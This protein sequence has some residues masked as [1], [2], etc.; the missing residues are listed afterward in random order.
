MQGLYLTAS[1]WK[2]FWAGHRLHGRD[3]AG[4][5]LS[6][7]PPDEFQIG[8]SH[9]LNDWSFQSRLAFRDD[10]D[11]IAGEG[12]EQAIPAA[13]LLS[14]SAGYQLSPRWKL[15]LSANNLLDEEYYPSADNKAPLAQGRSFALR[16]SWS[17]TP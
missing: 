7:I 10:K 14:A 3:A 15:A 8:L 9:E 1:P 12:K 5:P 17:G 2:L 11:D 4:Q 13:T 6:D 16:L